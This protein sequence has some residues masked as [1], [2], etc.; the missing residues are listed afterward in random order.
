[1]RVMREGWGLAV[2][3]GL[4]ASRVGAQP[5][6][7][8]AAGLAAAEALVRAAARSEAQGAVQRVAVAPTSAGCALV[9]RATVSPPGY[10]GTGAA[11]VLVGPDGRHY[12]R[13]AGEDVAP[14]LRAC[15][16][17]ARAPSP[18]EARALVS[19]GWYDGFLAT[20]TPPVVS[21]RAGRLRIAVRVVEALSGEDSERVVLEGTASGA[22]RLVR[23]P[24][25]APEEG[26]RDAGR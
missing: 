26:P 14:L 6:P 21:L 12:G 5:Q 9:V 22:V 15:G 8:R 20:R 16:W 10:P 4:L 2:V 18:E 17:F 3:V 11:S 1:M 19:G 25:S 24:A 7:A 23:V 13:R